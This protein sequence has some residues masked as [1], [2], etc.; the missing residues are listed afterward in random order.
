MLRPAFG[1]CTDQARQ[2]GKRDHYQHSLAQTCQLTILIQSSTEKQDEASGLEPLT[3]FTPR[4]FRDLFLRSLICFLDFSIL[5]SNPFCK[6][7]QLHQAQFTSTEQKVEPKSTQLSN[8]ALRPSKQ[9]ALL[10]TRPGRPLVPRA[11]HAL[12]L[13][14]ARS[15][16]P[17]ANSQYTFLRSPLSPRSQ[18]RWLC[19]PPACQPLVAYLTNFCLI[20]ST[21]GS[22][23][24]YL[25]NPAISLCS[26][27]C[28]Q[29]PSVAKLG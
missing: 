9:P 29:D 2:P 27:F 28:F 19:A 23:S 4:T 16:S 7:I 5:V 22:G 6:H 26:E 15:V 18:P 12:S 10:Q 13:G 11:V 17:F 14:S 21:P 20:T 3:F 8:Q 24:I 25:S 1:I